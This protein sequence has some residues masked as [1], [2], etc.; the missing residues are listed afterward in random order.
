[1]ARYAFD[2][3]GTVNIAEVAHLARALMRA[4]H[5]VYFITANPASRKTVKAKLHNLNLEGYT[6]LKQVKGKDNDEIGK[7]KGD[8]C[9]KYRISVYF[10]NDPEVLTGVAKVSRVARVMVMDTG[11]VA[12]LEEDL[13]KAK[14]KKKKRDVTCP[15]LNEVREFTGRRCYHCPEFLEFPWQRENHQ[16]RHHA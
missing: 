11:A 10:D 2:I 3:D 14:K 6:K 13:K 8:F 7:H 1:M 15:C 16:Q 12:A 5:K 4:N 9:D